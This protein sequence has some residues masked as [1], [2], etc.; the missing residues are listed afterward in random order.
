M[1]LIERIVERFNRIKGVKE[2][3]I[4]GDNNVITTPEVATPPKKLQ[5]KGK[6]NNVVIE[7]IPLQK[8]LQL[9]LEKQRKGIK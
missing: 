8:Q 1:N 2:L 7:H 5:I 3:V 4:I 9:R 6:N